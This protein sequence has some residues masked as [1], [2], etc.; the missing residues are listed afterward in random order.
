MHSASSQSRH[1]LYKD[2]KM[3]P[4]K[5]SQTLPKSVKIKPFRV[6]TRE[7]SYKDEGHSKVQDHDEQM[8]TQ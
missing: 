4:P 1:K 2:H 7:K 6:R 8:D 5:I 3:F